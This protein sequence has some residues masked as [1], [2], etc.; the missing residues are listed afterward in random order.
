MWDFIRMWEL[1]M[2]SLAKYAIVLSVVQGGLHLLYII[3]IAVAAI[4]ILS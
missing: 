1:S 3:I 4:I 2:T